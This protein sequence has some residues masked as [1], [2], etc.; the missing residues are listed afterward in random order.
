M[1]F[2]ILKNSI[3]ITGL[4]IIMMIMIEFVNVNSS[5]RILSKI[6]N[7]SFLQVF[8]AALFGIVPGCLG[9]FATVSL[10]THKV[11]SF[12][13]L[14]AMMI[15]SSGDEAFVMLAMIPK[16]AIPMFAGLFIIAIIVGVIV[17]RVRKNSIKLTE[18]CDNHEFEVHSNESPYTK[19]EKFS[20]RKVIILL[21][22]GIFSVTLLLGW[23]EHNHSHSV[24]PISSFEDVGSFSAAHSHGDDGCSDHSHDHS[25]NHSHQHTDTC[26]HDHSTSCSHSQSSHG[27]NGFNLLNERWMNIMFSILGLITFVLISISNEHFIKDHLWRHV[28]KKHLLSTFLWTFGAL[29]ILQYGISYLNFGELI[30][31]NLWAILL[32][33]VL[34]GIIPESGPHLLFVSMFAGGL[35]PVSILIANSIVQDGHTTLPLLASNKRAFAYAKLINVGVGILIGGGLMLLGL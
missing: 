23:M 5:G 20:I 4:V 11:I 15:C 9:G 28:I 3:L 32:I 12:G 24:D 17:D 30:Q 19:I 1:L 7:K 18:S 35:I 33:A 6:K 29:A 8:V 27:S 13:A 34:L 22:V 21:F 16:T 14:V 25:H 26:T 31:E 10:Y 2:E